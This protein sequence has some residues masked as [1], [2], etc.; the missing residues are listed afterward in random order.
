MLLGGLPRGPFGPRVVQM[1]SQHIS[2]QLRQKAPTVA[3]GDAFAFSLHPPH[4]NGFPTQC[5]TVIL[6]VARADEATRIHNRIIGLLLHPC[7][8][9]PMRSWAE[10][11]PLP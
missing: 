11:L 4:P 1:S 9:F 6:V 5:A 7:C 8:G 2:H 3:R 10:Q